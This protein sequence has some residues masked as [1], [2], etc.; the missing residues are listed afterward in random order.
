MSDDQY[1]INTPPMTTSV[2]VIHSHDINHYLEI[3]IDM[4]SASE[5]TRFSQYSVFMTFVS[6]FFKNIEIENNAEEFIIF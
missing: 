6:L 3:N 4:D 5:I 2:E 1:L